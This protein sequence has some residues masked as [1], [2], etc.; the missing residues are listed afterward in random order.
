M[1]ID[2]YLIRPSPI[3]SRKL[4]INRANSFRYATSSGPSDDAQL[5]AQ[6]PPP[7]GRKRESDFEPQASKHPSA[8]IKPCLSDGDF[9]EILIKVNDQEQQKSCDGHD[10][11]IYSPIVGQAES[12]DELVARNVRRRSSCSDVDEQ[13]ASWRD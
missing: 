3:H 4:F 13:Q 7:T 2:R 1:N 11:R 12:G 8:S 9:N 5:A 10:D 6:K